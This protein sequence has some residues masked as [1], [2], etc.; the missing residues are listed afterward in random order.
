MIFVDVLKLHVQLAVTA[1]PENSTST[2]LGFEF[3]TLHETNSESH[4]KLVVFGAMLV[5]KIFQ[6]YKL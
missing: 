3:A 6:G 5:F 2:I 4:L 1:T